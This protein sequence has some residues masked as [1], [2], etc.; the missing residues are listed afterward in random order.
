MIKAINKVLVNKKLRISLGLFFLVLYG[1][2]GSTDP[3]EL[4]D[5][6]TKTKA[7]IKQ[8]VDL[9]PAKETKINNDYTGLTKRS[10]FIS[11]DEF[12]KSQIASSN[13]VD[14]PDLSRSKGVLEKFALEDLTMVG[15]LKKDDNTI[16]ALL[17]DSKGRVYKIK[18]GSYIGLNYG[19]VIKINEKDIEVKEAVT[20]NYGGWR[21]NTVIL[22]LKE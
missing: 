1:C 3:A 12:V 9:L 20:N 6:L 11:S 17:A 5:F 4:Q 15:S 21:S 22:K 2:E 7:Q 8:A 18:E 16:W 10:P 14:A 19:K 13:E